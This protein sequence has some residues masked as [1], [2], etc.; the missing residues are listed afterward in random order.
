M[1]DTLGV[2]LIV[3]L[4][5]AGLGFMTYRKLSGQGGCSCCNPEGA[6]DSSPSCG[7]C[8]VAVGEDQR[9]ATYTE[10]TVEK[11]KI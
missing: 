8:D 3:T 7:S 2:I 5:V 6:S 4:A 1:L 11:V 9:T 10:V